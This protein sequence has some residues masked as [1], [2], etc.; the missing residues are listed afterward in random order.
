MGE[1]KRPI[2]KPVTENMLTEY[3]SSL[4]NVPLFE[5]SELANIDF[6]Q[7]QLPTSAK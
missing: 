2:N 1:A 3:L 5:K 4:S 6:R 7:N